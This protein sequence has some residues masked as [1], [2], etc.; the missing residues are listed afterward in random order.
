MLGLVQSVQQRVI[1]ASAGSTPS[2]A[3]RRSR[4]PRYSRS[5]WLQLPPTQVDLLPAGYSCLCGLCNAAVTVLDRKSGPLPLAR[6]L[7][8]RAWPFGQG[9]RVTPARAGSTGRVL[10]V[11]SRLPRPLQPSASSAPASEH[12][13]P[14]DRPTP[15]CAD[16]TIGRSRWCGCPPQPPRRPPDRVTPARAGS[17]QP[18]RPGRGRSTHHSRSC[19]LYY[20]PEVLVWLEGASFPLAQALP[21]RRSELGVYGR[22]TPACADCATRCGRRSGSGTGH[23]RLRGLSRNVRGCSVREGRATPARAGST[24][25]VLPAGPRPPRAL[26]PSAGRTACV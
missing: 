13:G 12:R 24:A 18:F 21:Q 23:S 3:S 19:G 1:L 10:P 17:T 22:V 20:R 7:Q 11:G 9:G 16:S 14:G 8:E 4:W 25:G 15:A 2:S 26:Q 5:R 6:A